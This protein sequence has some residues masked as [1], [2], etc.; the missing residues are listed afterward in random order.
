MHL[1]SLGDGGPYPKIL[2]PLRERPPVEQV[3]KGGKPAKN[4]NI[5]LK[6]SQK[7]L[8]KVGTLFLN[9]FPGFFTQVSQK[10]GLHCGDER[11]KERERE[12]ERGDL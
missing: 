2:E 6:F 5:H 10:L 7:S 8:M 1:V 9:H 3:R 4:S 12:R 11:E